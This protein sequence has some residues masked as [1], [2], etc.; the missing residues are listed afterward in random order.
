MKS[1]RL[2]TDDA[3]SASFGLAADEVLAQR[4]GQGKSEPTLRLYTYASHCALVGRFQNIENELHRHYCEQ[5]TIPINRRPTGGG[6]IIMGADQLGVALTI[7]GRKQD[8]YSRARE[9][10][11]QF[12]EG[13]VRGLQSLGVNAEFRRKNDIEVEGR[14]IAGLG[15]HKASSGGLL[16]HDS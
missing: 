16:L 12:S 1:W 6:T 4:V 7:P 10:M 9:L 14:K 11:G 15:I 5:H 3:V 8:T 2:I 13:V